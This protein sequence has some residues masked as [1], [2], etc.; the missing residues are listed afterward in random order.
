MGE[1]PAAHDDLRI[2]GGPPEGTNSEI[3][4][5]KLRRFGGP[6]SQTAVAQG[7]T[8][9]WGRSEQYQCVQQRDDES[10]EEQLGEFDIGIGLPFKRRR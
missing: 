6:M 2:A 7:T 1:A 4:T 10:D 8:R 5:M 9:Y 3:R